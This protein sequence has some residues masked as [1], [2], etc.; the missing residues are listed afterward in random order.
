VTWLKTGVIVS[1][2]LLLAVLFGAISYTGLVFKVVHYN[3][4]KEDNR[5]LEEEN[6]KIQAVVEEQRK[7]RDVLAQII[8]ALGGHLDLGSIPAPE[9]IGQDRQA[10][11][12]VDSALRRQRVQAAPSPSPTLSVESGS[13]RNDASAN[14][15]SSLSFDSESDIYDIPSKMPANGFISQGFS[16][17]SLFPERSHRG[18]DIA[19]HSGDPIVAAASGR[20]VFEGWTPAYGN[21]LVIS[22]PND[23]ITVYGHD[24]FNLKKVNQEVKRG[25]PIALLGSS[26]KSTAPHLH[27]E[28]W[29]DGVPVDPQEFIS[30]N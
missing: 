8:R 1:A 25:E 27:F 9:P 15:D 7:N 13:D 12:A 19:G 17:D 30:G 5:R 10:L 4:L 22:H 28:I 3:A 29:K 21:F 2:I 6:R 16:V 26:G 11:A 20:V 23:Y 14:G 24:Q 18:I